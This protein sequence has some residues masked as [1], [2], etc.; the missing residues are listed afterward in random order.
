MVAATMYP[1]DLNFRREVLLQLGADARQADELLAYNRNHFHHDLLA[2]PVSLP[3]ADEESVRAWREYACETSTSGVAKTLNR[4]FPQ[5]NFPV[6]H[7]MSDKPEYR[8]ATR[9]GV[10]WAGM[11][12]ATGLELRSPESLELLIHPTIAGHIP[13]LIA[14]DRSDFESMLCVFLHRNEPRAI[15]TSMGAAMVAGFNNWGRI[16]Q[17]HAAFTS[18]HPETSEEEWLDEFAARV[19]PQRHLYQDRFI[20]LSDSPYSGVP[21]EQPELSLIMRREHESMHYITKRLLG[22]MKNNLLDELIA[23]YAGIVAAAGEFRSDWFL[24]FMGL[25][26]YPHYHEGGRFQ[27]YLTDPL[28]PPDCL[29]LLR[30]LLV[31]GSENLSA[32]DRENL[33]QVRSPRGRTLMPLALCWLTL[34]VL[35]SDQANEF[36]SRAFDWIISN[37][38]IADNWQER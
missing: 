34:E 19:K 23:D 14:R 11:A 12:A 6:R 38:Q 26:N 29:A 16:A 13:I 22:S 28:I 18:A 7:G 30:A 5:L 1:I 32:F 24:Q 27:N 36:L 9:R 25:E 37:F 8:A 17:L 31:R 33:G 15:P 3:L 4:Y 10:P 2:L 20:L 35:A 21:Q